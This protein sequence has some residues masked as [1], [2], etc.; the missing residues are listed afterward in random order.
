ME[1]ILS[2][3]N[4]KEGILSRADT[5]ALE[6]NGLADDTVTHPQ[7]QKPGVVVLESPHKPSNL[8]SWLINKDI[9]AQRGA[10]TVLLL[11]FLFSLHHAVNKGQ[12]SLNQP[13][14]QDALSWAWVQN[15]R[16]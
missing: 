1:D 7:T 3:R 13:D 6:A 8:I 12:C 2:S 16:P 10:K 9:E 11:S 4:S 5:S 14:A 15:H